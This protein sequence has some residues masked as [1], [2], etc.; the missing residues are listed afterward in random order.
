MGLNV[1]GNGDDLISHKAVGPRN[2]Y[3]GRWRRKQ[4]AGVVRSAWTVMAEMGD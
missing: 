3:S 2:T 1:D 4:R